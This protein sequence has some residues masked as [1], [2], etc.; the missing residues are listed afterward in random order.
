MD[1]ICS[2]ARRTK[3]KEKRKL[4][5]CSFHDCETIENEEIEEKKNKALLHRMECE[6]L[7]AKSTH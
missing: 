1:C 2:T 5:K 3:R 4:R 7:R 6:S